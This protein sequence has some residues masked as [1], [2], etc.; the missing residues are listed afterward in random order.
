MSFKKQ[1]EQ[2]KDQQEMSRRQD[3][4]LELQ[5]KELKESFRQRRRAQAA[6]LLNRCRA[7]AM[8]Q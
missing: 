2:L 8:R 3:A 1:T 5:A 6:Q 4:T 7:S